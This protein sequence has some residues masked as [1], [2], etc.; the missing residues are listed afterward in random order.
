M[1]PLG[2]GH[3]L[4]SN[5]VNLYTILKQK[6]STSFVKLTDQWGHQWEGIKLTVEFTDHDRWKGLKLEQYYV[7]LPESPVIATFYDINYP[8]QLLHADAIKSV[9]FLEKKKHRYTSI[10]LIQ[11]NYLTNLD[12][13]SLKSHFPQ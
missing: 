2:W 8:N 4:N 1:E 3:S 10:H 13:K 5:N 6:I 12:Q 9:A 7:T 11:T